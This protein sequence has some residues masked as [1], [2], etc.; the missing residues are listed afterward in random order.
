MDFF[1]LQ[2][3]TGLP[4]LGPDKYQQVSMLS[5][6][7]VLATLLTFNFWSVDQKYC[8]W[9][10]IWSANHTIFSDDV[11]LIQWNYI[12]IWATKW[13]LCC[14]SREC[15]ECYLISNFN[16]IR[17]ELLGLGLHWRQV[18]RHQL[19]DY[20]FVTECFDSFYPASVGQLVVL[21]WWLRPWAVTTSLFVWSVWVWLSVWWLQ[22][23]N[24]KSL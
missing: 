15:R 4:L 12:K 11:F 6:V 1:C 10:V 2:S 19:A 13:W 16:V 20:G 23:F 14:W 5:S 17:T 18:C 21:M 22:S 3:L 9:L 8:V 7:K 24:S